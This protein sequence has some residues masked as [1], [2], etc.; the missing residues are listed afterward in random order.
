MI[1][2]KSVTGLDVQACS[3]PTCRPCCQPTRPPPPGRLSFANL[4]AAVQKCVDA[5]A[6]PPHDD[7]FRMASLIWTAEHGIVLARI[8]RPPFPG[9]HWTRSST[10]R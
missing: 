8:A 4:V 6:A 9:R 2:V 7:P 10:T 1:I 5:G 3:R